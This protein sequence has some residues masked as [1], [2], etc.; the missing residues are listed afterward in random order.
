MRS[1]KITARSAWLLLAF[2]TLLNVVNF[3]DRQ[4]L[5]SLQVPIK[6]DLQLTH[7]QFTLLAGYAFVTLYATFGLFLGTVADRWNR[8]RLIALGLF[9]ASVAT[10]AS[11]LATNFWDLALLR[12]SGSASA[13]PR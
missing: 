8:P 2:L 5:I 11:R 6:R 3:I 13:R 7:V 4:L 9:V 1:R 12:A 10:A